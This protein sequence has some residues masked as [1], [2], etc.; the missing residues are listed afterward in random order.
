M[1]LLLGTVL[2]WGCALPV[3]AKAKKVKLSPEARAAQKRN[4]ALQ[5]QAKKL[6]KAR[7]KEI[8][9]LKAGH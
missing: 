7:Q 8:K 6:A 3:Y 9:R 1:A 2:S 5:K 4:K